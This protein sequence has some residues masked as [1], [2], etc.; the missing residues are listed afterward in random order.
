MLTSRPLSKDSS[1]NPAL[2]DSYAADYDGQVRAYAC[3]ITDLMFGLCYEFI[4]PG[5]SLLDV[6]AGSGLSAQPFAKA[7]LQVSGMDFSPAMLE[8]CQAKGFFADLQQHDLTTIP[9]PYPT[10]RFDH[11]IACGVFHFIPQMDTIF[12]E[13][14]RLLKPGGL[15]A[16]STRFPTSKEQEGLYIRHLDGDFEIFSHSTQYIEAMLKQSQLIRLKLQKCFIGE[17]I[18]LI[19]VAQKSPQS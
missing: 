17:D 10:N 7:G 14:V 11:L 2:H 12:T 16:F 4:C 19:W 9:W 18:F 3:Y 5:Q 8:I 1:V 13:A 15:F 6:G